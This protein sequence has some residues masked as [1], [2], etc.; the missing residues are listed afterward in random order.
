MDNK[1]VLCDTG[2]FGNHAFELCPGST[3]RTVDVTAGGH[4]VYRCGEARI[5]RT[6]PI[7]PSPSSETYFLR[8]RLARIELFRVSHA[9]HEVRAD[10]RCFDESGLRGGCVVAVPP[11]DRGIPC[12]V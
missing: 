6:R 7:F 8:I 3:P 2:P 1:W 11:P 10:A 4:V 9:D 5:R 12:R